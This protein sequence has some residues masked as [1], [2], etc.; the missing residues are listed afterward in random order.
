MEKEEKEDNIPPYPANHINKI[1]PVT[2][3]KGT[4]A[5]KPDKKEVKTNT[6]NSYN[7]T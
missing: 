6:H 5:I 3:I 4:T 7:L 1:S 2:R